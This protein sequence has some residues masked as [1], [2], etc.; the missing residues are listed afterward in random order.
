MSPD[1]ATL[2]KALARCTFVPGSWDKRFVERIDRARY[3]ESARGLSPRQE[4]SLR[5]LVQ[6]YHRQL[7]ADVVA[8]AA[9]LRPVE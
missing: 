2:A 1:Y 6:K 8:L 9:S 7:P 4:E 3:D 5:R